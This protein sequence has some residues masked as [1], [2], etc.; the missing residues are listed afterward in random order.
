MIDWRRVVAR[1]A[2][3]FYLATC[4]DRDVKLKELCAASQRMIVER[5][6]DAEEA[7]ALQ[8]AL[9]PA[10]PAKPPP[11]PKP[12]SPPKS[13]RGALARVLAPEPEPE[14]SGALAHL[15]PDEPVVEDVT[16]EAE[17]RRAEDHNALNVDLTR[18]ERE[19]VYRG[20]ALVK[21]AKS[22]NGAAFRA[23][24]RAAARRPITGGTEKL[25]EA[26]APLGLATA[27]LT[28]WFD[29][30]ELRS[31]SGEVDKLTQ[32]LYD[33]E[34]SAHEALK[35][36]KEN[37]TLEAWLMERY[38]DETD[39]P[40]LALVCGLAS[41]H[42]DGGFADQCRTQAPI[43][44]RYAKCIRPL[45]TSV[46]CKPLIGEIVASRPSVLEEADDPPRN[47]PAPGARVVSTDDIKRTGPCFCCGASRT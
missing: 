16:D 27:H 34:S 7:L 9:A 26:S 8:R 47:P 30:K 40:A 22:A 10:T 13:I 33:E 42:C 43:L 23:A 15:K 29:D 24:L 21:A 17:A 28:R 45:N 4:A 1:R 32:L 14:L 38:R 20:E 11:P 2:A 44:K 46:A 37:S 19:D 3:A 35:V 36:L 6:K 39:A 31:T 25:R 41:E 5:Q 12:A 18:F